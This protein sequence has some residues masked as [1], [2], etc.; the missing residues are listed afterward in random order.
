MK[1][2]LYRLL[3]F[4]TIIILPLAFGVFMP[5][6]PYASKSL[7]FGNLLKD[8]LMENVESP[9]IIF[10]GGSNLSFGLNSQLIKDSLKLN[11]IN[12]GIHA[13]I[14]LIYMLSNSLEFIKKGD[15]VVLVPEYQQF[16]GDAAFGSEG[17][18]LTRTIFDVNKSK[19]KLL[20]SV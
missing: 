2:F 9:R 8:S 11:P 17:E 16:Y 12:A 20:Y 14:G 3:F 4:L 6:T 19:F 5:A 13:S 7:I 15:I 10:L 18:E 1:K